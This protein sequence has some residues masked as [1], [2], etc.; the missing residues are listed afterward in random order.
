MSYPAHEIQ[1]AIDSLNELITQNT[2]AFTSAGL[3]PANIKTALTTQATN[4]AQKDTAQENA[5]T[6]LKTATNN[7]NAAADAAY[8]LLSSTID[9]L[10]GA[11]GKTTPLA[12]QVYAVRRKLTNRKRGGGSNGNGS[13]SSS[14]TSS[15]SGGGGSSSSSP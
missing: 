10:G 6:A 8:N 9:V 1:G 3:T 15:S 13:S 5:K 7:Y 14:A 11:V 2:A 4:V 12:Q